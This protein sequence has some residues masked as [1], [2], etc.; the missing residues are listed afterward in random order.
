MRQWF[1]LAVAALVLSAIGFALGA[2]QTDVYR[3]LLLW[4]TLALGYNFLFGI[5]GQVAFSH[6]TFYGS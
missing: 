3:K 5:A 6:F 2:Y 4:V 1:V